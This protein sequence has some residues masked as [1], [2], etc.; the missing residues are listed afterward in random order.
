MPTIRAYAEADWPQVERIM[1]DGINTGQ[2]TFDTKPK[3]KHVWEGESIA[4]T[5]LVAVE[6]NK[7]CGWVLLW[8][9]SNRCAYAGVAEVSIYVAAETAGRGIGK[10]LLRAVIVASEE[11]GIWSIQSGIFKENEGSIALHLSCGFR[12]IGYRERIGKHNGVWR[13]TQQYERRSEII[14]ID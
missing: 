13:D 3:A 11:V 8:P 7:V 2:A 12:Y 1:Q 4:E 5:Q 14:S 6:G 9:T 10:A